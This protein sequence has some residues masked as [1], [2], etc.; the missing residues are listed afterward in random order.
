MRM[1]IATEIVL[2]K[3]A[4]MKINKV[5]KNEQ[6]NKENVS[7]N[8]FR[9]FSVENKVASEINSYKVISTYKY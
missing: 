2:M 4:L 8:W 6:A 1:K 5:Q 3:T 7:E 9:F